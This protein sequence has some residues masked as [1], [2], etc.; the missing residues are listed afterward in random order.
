[1]KIL[2]IRQFESEE[3]SANFYCNTFK[4]HV[5][6]H[7]EKIAAPHKHDF[8]L[9]VLFTKGSGI[10]EIDF[11]SYPIEPGSVFFLY[12]GQTHYWKLSND[13]DGFIFFHSREFFELGFKDYSISQFPFYY[14]SHNPPN[15]NLS[16]D[17]RA[18]IVSL[19]QEL[20]NEN[21]QKNLLRRQKISSLLN[22]IYIDLSRIYIQAYTKELTRSRVYSSHMK[23]F[24]E[25]IETNFSFQ[26]SAADYAEMMNM[27]PKH[28]NR[29]TKQMLGKTPT[30]LITER[31]LLEAKRMLV[32]SDDSFANIS[33][34]LGYEDYPYFSRIFKKW[35][36]ITPTEFVSKYDRE[37]YNR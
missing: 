6:T 12:P 15:L 13:V 23:K 7:Q 20:Y 34:A 8:F 18:S 24:E 31:I 5:I 17:E 9:T 2:N 35:T 36:G 25:L 30:Q 4:T 21:Q 27:T 10:H 14:S 22:L 3:V 11:D 1:M 26:K 29:L 19:F 28:L 32:Y 16:S 33:I 37:Y